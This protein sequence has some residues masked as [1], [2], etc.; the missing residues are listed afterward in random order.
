MALFDK[1]TKCSLDFPSKPCIVTAKLGDVKID[2]YSTNYESKVP[3]HRI[4]FI[5]ILN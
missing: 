2:M 4:A 3:K 5:I 1:D